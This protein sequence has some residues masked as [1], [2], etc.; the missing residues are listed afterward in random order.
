MRVVLAATIYCFT[1]CVVYAWAAE[2]YIVKDGQPNA[3]III[4]EDAPR[5]AQLAAQEMQ[6][7]IEK[8]SGAKLNIGTGAR[9]D[10]AVAIYI[11]RSPQTERLGI[12]GNGLAY[13]AYRIVSGDDWLV[14][15]GDDADFVPIEPWARNN[16]QLVNGKTQAAWDVITGEHWGYSHAQ[17]RKHYTGSASFFGTP[18]EQHHDADGNVN[19]WGFDERGSFNAVCAFLRSLG[20]RWYMPG[21]LGEI[22]PRLETIALPQIDQTVHPDFPLRAFNIR[23]GVHGR[24]VAMWAMRLGLRDP[25]GRQAAHGMA[26]MTRT[27]HTVQNHPDWFA[28]YN[29]ERRARVG[30]RNNQL[31]YSNEELFEHA[32]RWVRAEFDHFDMRAVS[33]MPPDGYTRMCECDLCAGKDTP[34]RGPRGALSDYVWDFVNRVAKEVAKT[35]PDRFV[36]NAAYGVYTQPPQRIDKLEPNVQVIIVGGRRPASPE[37]DAIRELREVWATKTDNP[38]VIF[39]NYPFTGRGF[40]LPAYI[41]HVIGESINASKGISRG[42]DIW[43]TA[44]FGKDATGYNHFQTYFTARMYWGGKEQRV[45]ELFEEYCQ[46]FYGP[47][48][49]GMRAFFTYCET[50]WREMEHDEATASHALELFALAKGMAPENSVYAERIALIDNY[51]SGLRNKRGQLAQKRGPVPRLRLVGDARGK[52]VVD[53]K[54]DDSLWENCPVAS[55]GQLR[56][57]QT[58][59]LPTFGTTIKS[60]WIGNDLY[61]AIRCDEPTGE[62][63][64]VAAPEDGGKAIWS[65]DLVEVLLDTDSHSYYQIAINPAG[66]VV[67][68]DRGASEN[69]RFKWSSQAEVATHVGDGAWTVEMRIPV[70][71]DANDPLH[72]IVGHKPTQSLPWHI[73]VC[74]QRIREHASEYSAFAPTG[75]DSFHEPMKFA[76]FYRGRSHQFE[77]DPT[78]TDYITERRTADKLLRD[79]KREEA[80]EAFEDLAIRDGLTDLQRSDALSLAAH[81]ARTLKDFERAE[82]FAHQAPVKAVGKTIRMQNLLARRDFDEL[83][84]EFGEVDF[85]AWPFWSAG[86]AFFARGRAYIATRQAER[87]DAD[88]R[89]ALVLTPDKRKRKEILRALGEEP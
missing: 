26:H 77:A 89:A 10:A 46:T 65:G 8:I 29:G 19:V 55:T 70:T 7:Y 16:N 88:L 22:A 17:I 54:L 72:Q 81:A 25:Y 68:Q 57:L 3:E 11:G 35:H 38:I 40:Y 43:L 14:L 51:L 47:A 85:G 44:D 1:S 6:T 15:I 86:E 52:I 5:T 56:E 30:R 73:N 62:A 31:C 69:N 58:G 37:R 61:L 34:V 60:L 71:D 36:S 32:V 41:P 87:A 53:G 24:D 12:T 4:A 9:T 42:E 21:T 33:V 67:D 48:A 74:R 63:L 20:V 80:L 23:F 82:Q 83:L 27:D 2:S 78:V 84:E 79:R 45:A 59:R 13:G 49:T 28:L 66:A 18:K 39:E 64:N 50:N 76:H 75:T